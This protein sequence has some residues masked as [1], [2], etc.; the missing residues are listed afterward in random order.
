MDELHQA[1]RSVL[2]ALGMADV[3]GDELNDLTLCI[4]DTGKLPEATTIPIMRLIS[5]LSK[6]IK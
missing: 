2:A 4:G 6:H 5:V 3:G 1:V